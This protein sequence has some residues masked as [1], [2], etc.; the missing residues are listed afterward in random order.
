PDFD[1][2]IKN[3]G[4]D[5]GLADVDEGHG[6]HVA[7][8]VLGSG[9]LSAGLPGLKGPIRGLA[10]QAKLVFQAVEQELK[11]KNPADLEENGRF[12]LAGI[13][14]DLTE[15]FKQA[16]QKGARIHSNSWGGGK[17]GEYDEQCRQLD[18]F[19]WDNKD[20]C[21]LVAAGND[22]TDKDGDGKINFK[23]VTSTA[24]AKNCITVGACENLRTKFNSEV[25]GDWWPD[26]Y[27]SAPFKN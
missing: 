27:P 10:Y 15:L 24:T 9:A 13:P 7:G 16:Y 23:S 1:K 4:G 14:N 5:D 2:Y 19:V 3:P 26:D 6:T 12:L 11:W 20:F 8:S 17:P 21:V 18:Q 22:G 25:Y